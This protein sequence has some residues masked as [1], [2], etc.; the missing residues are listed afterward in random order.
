M[1][2]RGLASQEAQHGKK[3]IEVKLRFWTNNIADEPGRIVPKN[4]WT[5]GV[6]RVERNEVHGIKPHGP[7]PFHTLLDVGAVIEKVLIEHGIVLH[8]A[9]KMRKYISGS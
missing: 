3:M 6:V 1:P 9:P 4:A 8:M 2:R 7:K 5:S